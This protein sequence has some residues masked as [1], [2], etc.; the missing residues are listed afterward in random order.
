MVDT[1]EAFDAWKG[2]W[3]DGPGVFASRVTELFAPKMAAA[4]LSRRPD[5]VIVASLF[6]D[7]SF[8]GWVSSISLLFLPLVLVPSLAA[9]IVFRLHRTE[10]TPTLP[11]SNNMAGPIRK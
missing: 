5:L 4:G 6:W 7:D 8:L 10:A 9:H 11:R 3:E 1:E 2:K